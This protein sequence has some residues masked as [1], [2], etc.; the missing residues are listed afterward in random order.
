MKIPKHVAFILDGNRR[1]G[2]LVLNNRLAGHKYGAEKIGDV[3]QWCRDFNIRTVT[4]WGFST[5][6]FN[7]PENE[8]KLLMNLFADKFNQ[9][10]EAKE[11]H[12]N[13][14]R[15][16]VYGQIN[17]FPEKVQK[18]IKKTVDSTKR[19][20][21]YFIN[22]AIG[23]GGKQEIL[24]VAKKLSEKFASGEIKEITKQEF[25]AAMYFDLPD[26]DLIIR[27]GGVQ[28]TSGFMP[29]KGALAEWYFTEK[30]WPEFDKSEF[31]RALENYSRRERRFGI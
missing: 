1:F 5:E 29:W 18:A 20:N 31:V 6:N 10:A 16:Q 12:E 17:L 27:T 4:L 24:D 15:I 13:K 19:Y 26:I 9:L 7:R 23:Y 3:L 14:I 30:F 25:E 28:R 21:S 8:V 22:F 2:K 11:V